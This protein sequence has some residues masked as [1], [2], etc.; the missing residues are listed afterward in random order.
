V[1]GG[2]DLPQ[3]IEFSKLLKDLGIDLIDCSSGGLVADAVI[4]VAPNFQVPFADAI[5]REAGIA[6][7]AVGLIT[8]PKQAEEI[9]RNGQAD[10]IM[11]ARQ[12]LRE[13]YLAIRAAKELEAKID[14]PKQYGRA[15]A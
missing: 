12:F 10:A 3:S 13:P 7:V 15:I 9:L 8:E 14:I 2:W 5:R 1:E 4:P 6:T 11:V